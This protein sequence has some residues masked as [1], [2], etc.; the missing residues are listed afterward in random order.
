ME[1]GP[2]GEFIEVLE[3]RFGRH[4]STGFVFISAMGIT[5]LSIGLIYRNIVLP[6][7]H[8]VQY[9]AGAHNLYDLLKNQWVS[10]LDTLLVMFI[11]WILAQEFIIRVTNYRVNKTVKEAKADA[12]RY[13]VQLEAEFEKTLNDKHK[14]D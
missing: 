8:A 9:L 11:I 7:Y 2:L 12:L 3:K 6:V 10:L 5:A 14:D 4:V 1:F 13:F